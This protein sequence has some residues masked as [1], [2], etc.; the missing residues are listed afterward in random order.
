MVNGIWHDLT[1][2]FPVRYPMEQMGAGAKITFDGNVYFNEFIAAYIFQRKT[3]RVSTG[4]R[5]RRDGAIYVHV[6][7]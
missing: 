4:C 6:C 1:G 7:V 3:L 2:T 5:L